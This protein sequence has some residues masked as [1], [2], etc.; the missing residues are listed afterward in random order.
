MF[1]SYTSPAQSE[2]SVYT[3][4]PNDVIASTH[5]NLQTFDKVSDNFHAQRK[6]L[7]MELIGILNDPKSS[8]LSQCEAACYL[9]EMRMS[10]AAD[11]LAAKITLRLDLRHIIILHLPA[12]S[13]SPV[14]DALV[15][16]GNPSIPAVIRNLAE[17]DDAKVREL[18]LKVL[19]RIDGD[20]DIVR[21]RLQKALK[22][23]TDSTKQAR[24]QAALN[25][26]E[27]L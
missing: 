4:N 5:A 11:D 3:L 26:S 2:K 17:S 19:Y 16:I 18:S 1:F 24:L 20:K 12:I 23:E 8:N 25:Q 10:E 7:C 21:L 22:A 27:K 9:G 6:Q 14:T 13:A 15:K